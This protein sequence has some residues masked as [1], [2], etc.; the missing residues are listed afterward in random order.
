MGPAMQ[1][2][3]VEVHDAA[4]AAERES[5]VMAV[6]DEILAAVLQ[7]PPTTPDGGP[8]RRLQRG[9]CDDCWHT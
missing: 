4:H 8:G 7:E 1:A 9:K 3:G 6:A 5:L 2:E